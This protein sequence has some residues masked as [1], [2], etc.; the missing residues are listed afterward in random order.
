MYYYLITVYCAG[1]SMSSALRPWKESWLVLT[2][3]EGKSSLLSMLPVNEEKLRY[4]S[5]KYE[6]K[7]CI[8]IKQK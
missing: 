4:E 2:S 8:F 5:I 1:L 3:T 6:T 7:L